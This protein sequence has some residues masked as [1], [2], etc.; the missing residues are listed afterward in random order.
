MKKILLLSFLLSCVVK[1]WSAPSRP[2]EIVQ[3]YADN[4]SA[5]SE[6]KDVAFYSGA[7]QKL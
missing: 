6:T 1:I 7:I 5:W 3:A 2:I 4:L